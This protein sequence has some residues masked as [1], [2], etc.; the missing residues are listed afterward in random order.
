[1]KD[2][3]RSRITRIISGTA[4]SIVTKIEG[5]APEAVLEQAIHEVDGAIDEVRSELGRIIAQKHHVTKAITRLNEEH[6]KLDEQIETALGTDRKDLAEAAI[7]RQV[8]IEDQLPALENQLADASGQEKELNQA[9][10]GLLAKRHEMDEEL[11]TFKKNRREASAAAGAATGG[12][13]AGGGV[14]PTAKA[15]K[16]EN[17]FKRVLEDSTGVR[18]GDF[19][20]S[21]EDRHKLLELSE[22]NRKAKIEARL[23][24]RAE[25]H[26]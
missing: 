23:K 4:S 22:L 19:R 14:S 17:A 26:S 24:E 16:A 1:M 12:G 6:S 21:E 15:Q 18:R 7:S 20:A 11:F 8:D 5:L 10:A 3:I 2:S 9:V 13:S 25:R